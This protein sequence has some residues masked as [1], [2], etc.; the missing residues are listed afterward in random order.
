MSTE[1][2][3]V[4]VIGPGSQPESDDGL[5]S[6]F[7][8]FPQDI[9]VYRAPPLPEPEAVTGL[10][11]AFQRAARL[12]RELGDFCP[13]GRQRV[14][15]L[16]DLDDECRQFFDQ[17]LGNGEV[18]IQYQSSVRAQIQES[19]LA[20][21]WRVR[22]LDAKG[23]VTRDTVE[24]G[25]IPAVVRW[26]TFTQAQSELHPEDIE[27][28]GD[29][30]N[31]APLLTEI[32]DR[33]PHSARAS[34]PHVINLSLLPHSQQDLQFLS[35]VLGTGPTLILS[36]GYGN[37]RISS[38]ATLNTWWVQYFNSQETLIL[39]TLEISAIPDVA[40]AAVEDIADSR[41][42]LLEIL[43]VYGVSDD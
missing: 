3:P 10:G 14:I 17:L 7:Q 41:Q 21:V 38:T 39:N 40:C 27:F 15:E 13:D 37:C 4:T 25:D 31:A 8:Q 33:L 43:A 18:S 26:Q 42:R 12:A 9:S 5:K 11:V 16:D 29:L 1:Y 24:V 19:V 30:Y 6:D 34:R 28:P 2:I 20:G 35:T 36:R 32:A 23:Q 22:Y